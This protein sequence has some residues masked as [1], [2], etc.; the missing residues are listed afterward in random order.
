MNGERDRK[1]RLISMF[2]TVLRR[3]AARPSLSQN[4]FRYTEHEALNQ[5]TYHVVEFIIALFLVPMTH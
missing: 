5:R 3:D 4:M 2:L 1:F